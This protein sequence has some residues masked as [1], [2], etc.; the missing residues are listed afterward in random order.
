MDAWSPLGRGCLSCRFAAGAALCGPW[1]PVVRISWQAQHAEPSGGL[2]GC[3]VA[4][5]P[6][7]PVVQISWHAQ[8]LVNLE[9]IDFVAGAVHTTHHTPLITH[10][11]SYTTHRPPLI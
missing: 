2:D 8:H 7:L 11:S 10:H 9:F 3:V 6:R 1:L 5:W 4:A